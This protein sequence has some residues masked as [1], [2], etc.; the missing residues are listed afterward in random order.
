MSEKELQYPGGTIIDFEGLDCSFKETNARAFTEKIVNMFPTCPTLYESFPRYDKESSKFVQKWLNGSY[1]RQVLMNHPEAVDSFYSIDRFDFWHS[2]QGDYPITTHTFYRMRMFMFIFDRYNIS[3]AIYNPMSGDM[4]SVEDFTFDNRVYAIPQP[5]VVVWMRMPSFD[6]FKAILAE[7]KNKDKNESDMEFIKK[8]WERS[9]YAIENNLF[10]Q[11][12]IHL[13]TV[14]CLEEYPVE[15]YKNQIMSD[16]CFSVASTEE[17]NV[18]MCGYRIK[19]K[20]EL[21]NEVWEKVT[22]YLISVQAD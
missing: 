8:V 14:D 21:A 11:A 22:S 2:F 15:L 19:S 10:E 3:N 4:P 9:E 1:D 17:Y 16:K 6:A 7:K 12:G 20:E 18:H 5:D 13:I